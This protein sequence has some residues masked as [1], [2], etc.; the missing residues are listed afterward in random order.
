[1]TNREIVY[2]PHHQ[3]RSQTAHRLDQAGVVAV[4]RRAD[5]ADRAADVMARCLCLHRPRAASDAAEFRHF[6]HQSGFPRSVVDHRDHRHHVRLHL[7]PRRSADRMAGL[8]H[9]YARA[10]IDPRAG[11]R[12][13]R[14]AAVSRCG[15]LGIAGGAQ[16]RTA[17]PALSF[18]DRRRIRCASVRHL[19]ADRNHF[20]DFLLHLSVRVR[21]GRSRML[22]PSSA[23]RRGPPHAASRS[24]WHFPPLSQAA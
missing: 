18:H 15:R 11:D 2:D 10:S 12:F 21:A 14:D 20:R 13:L 5:R 3:H 16:Q 9:R 23:A 6:V 1:M 7:L 17:E 8:A 24:P 19:F 4:C 22:P